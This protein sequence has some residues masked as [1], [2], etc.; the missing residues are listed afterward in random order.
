M[1]VLRTACNVPHQRYL[2]KLNPK[3]SH[4]PLKLLVKEFDLIKETWSEFSSLILLYV[5]ISDQLKIDIFIWSDYFCLSHCISKYTLRYRND[6]PR[7][8]L[9]VKGL[10]MQ[11]LFDST[12]KWLNFGAS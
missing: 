12:C 7:S 1:Y 3:K 5:D 11:I 2:V 10:C 9:V 6:A 4:N 8:N